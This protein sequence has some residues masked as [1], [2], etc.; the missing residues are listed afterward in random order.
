MANPSRLG[1]GDLSKSSKN[2]AQKVIHSEETDKYAP[3]ARTRKKSF[4]GI[5]FFDQL[6][7]LFDKKFKEIIIKILTRPEETAELKVDLNKEKV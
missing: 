2:Q 4:F 5:S 3:N 6:T 1:E 7:N